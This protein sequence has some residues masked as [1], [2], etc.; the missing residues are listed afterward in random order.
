MVEPA[1]IVVIRGAELPFRAVQGDGAAGLSLAR[2][3]QAP[4]QA[5]TFQMARIE[6]G[7][8]S[9]R[10][11]HPWEQCNWVVSGRGLVDTGV[12]GEQIPISAG[13]CLI[14]PGGIDHAISN[15]GAE[16]LVLVAVLG[17]GAA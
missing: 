5:F 10:H 2:L 1:S 9:R 17:A 11:R 16:P 4:G 7:G 8:I 6:P 15:T 13:D 3:Y 14:F 12:D